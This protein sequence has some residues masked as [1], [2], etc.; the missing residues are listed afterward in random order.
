MPDEIDLSVRQKAKT[1]ETEELRDHAANLL[2]CDGILA[3][4]IEQMWFFAER[5]EILKTLRRAIAVLDTGEDQGFELAAH[6]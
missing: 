5:E 2:E 1:R 6:Y 4:A 3:D